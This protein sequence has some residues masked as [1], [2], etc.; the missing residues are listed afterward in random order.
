MEHEDPAVRRFRERIE[1]TPFGF[2]GSRHAPTHTGGLVEGTLGAA[3]GLE[4]DGNRSGRDPNR[5]LPEPEK[6]TKPNPVE[7][8]PIEPEV[9][10]T[11]GEITVI[12]PVKAR[13]EA[14]G[15]FRNSDFIEAEVVPPPTLADE[16]VNL[17]RR[18]VRRAIL[19]I[20]EVVEEWG[21]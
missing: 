6:V 2:Y 17:G 15:A 16:F 8:E 13:R 21:D 4:G 5:A 10:E 14:R 11:L 20:H 3:L 7:V 1:A 9:V 19:D 12:K 18:A